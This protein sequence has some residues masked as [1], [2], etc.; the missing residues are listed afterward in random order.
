[1][2]RYKE[3]LER[4]RRYYNRFKQINNGMEQ[5]SPSEEF[6]DDIYAFFQNCYHLK[7][8]LINDSAF[9]RYTESEIEKHIKKTPPLAI[10]A[11]ICNASKHLKL[12]RIRSGDKPIL[13]RRVISLGVTTGGDVPT[14]I[15]MQVEFEHDGRTLDA[16][17]VATDALNSWESFLS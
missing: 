3:Q 7:D 4:V 6:M 12:T 10:C 15:A 14:K 8:W 1:M 11:D 13:G 17:Q 5:T 16:F 2:A 9:T